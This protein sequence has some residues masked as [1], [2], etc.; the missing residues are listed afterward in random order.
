VQG[1]GVRYGLRA[2]VR[3]DADTGK[4]RLQVREY[5][6]GVQLAPTTLSPIVRFTPEWQPLSADYVT[7]SDSST[8]DFQVIDQPAEA[9]EVFDVDDL[10]IQILPNLPAAAPEP[11]RG[12]ALAARFAPNPMLSAGHLSFTLPQPGAARVQI[13]DAQGRRVRTLLDRADLQA[14]T[15]SVRFDGRDDAGGSLAPGVY[16]YRV[17]AGDRVA[18]GRFLLLR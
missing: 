2:W 4:A 5:K 1:R 11:P 7:V 15:H 16:F 12:R 10:S 3:S 8:I 17:R 18:T 13:L 6:D 9:G 14:G